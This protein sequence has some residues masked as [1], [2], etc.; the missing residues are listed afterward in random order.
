MQNDNENV[1]VTDENNQYIETIKKMKD[2]MVDK[3]EY[4]KLKMENKS[5]LDSIINGNDYDLP[6]QEEKADVNK[7]REEL[8][9]GDNSNL[10]FVDKALK[11]RTEL[12]EKGESD[13]FL[14]VGK[15]IQPTEEDIATANRV[16]K[17]LQEC[18]DY[19]QGDS[20]VFTTELQRRTIDTNI[21]I[22]R[23]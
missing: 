16:A 19:A 2:T 11:L 13:P 9:A 21:N 14:P 5:L 17:V 10:E 15:N 3:T 23:K 8:F 7:L 6:E 4:D 18:V 12:I 20:S 1:E 22:K